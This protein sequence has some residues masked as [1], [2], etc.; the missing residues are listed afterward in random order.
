MLV[1]VEETKVV[2]LDTQSRGVGVVPRLF[3]VWLRCR[4]QNNFFFIHSYAVISVS[5]LIF[6]DFYNHYC[7][8]EIGF[9]VTFAVVLP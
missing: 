3:W 9:K 4:H 2:D 7:I 5:T 8:I 1:F 6:H